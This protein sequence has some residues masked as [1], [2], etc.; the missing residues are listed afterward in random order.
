MLQF[1]L[2]A[3]KNVVDNTDQCDNNC[4]VFWTVTVDRRLL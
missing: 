4:P 1:V 3:M 2:F